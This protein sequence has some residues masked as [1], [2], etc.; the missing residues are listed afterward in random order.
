VKIIFF[1]RK[2]YPH[3]FSIEKVFDGIRKNIANENATIEKAVM[4]FYSS[5]IFF[6]IKNVLW[7]K[8]HQGDVN[9]ITGDVHYI[10]LG[11]VKR[12][13]ILTIHDL[14][15]LNHRN[16]L[17]RFILRIFWLT[18]PLKKVA[19][20]TVISEATKKDLLSRIKSQ[21]QQIKVIPNYYDSA[22][23]F[24]SKEFNESKPTI[25][26]I[27]TKENKNVLRL[28]EALEGVNCH[29]VIIGGDN[30]KIEEHLERYK[31]SFTWL[32]NLTDDE[33]MEQYQKCDIVTLVSTIEG[34]GMPILEAQAIGR[35]VLTSNISSMPEV[36]GDAACF[37]DPFS[38]VSIREGILKV[39]ENANYR[40]DLIEKGL[41]NIRRFEL[42]KISKMYS[43]LYQH[44]YTNSS[45][46]KEQGA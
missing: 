20:V 24:F 1:Q 18:L 35:V 12:K 42:S 29:L 21:E 3:Q 41:M 14:N 46:N 37:V 15:F 38:V 4:P 25:L 32:Q 30:K 6:R 28:I 17:A 39:V 40:K 2:S 44:V 16:R 9:H 43:D 19:Y 11:L 34:F 31:V 8:M 7:S 27:G 13:T 45:K 5:G 26:Q 22:F 23:K 36:A 33:L 10:A